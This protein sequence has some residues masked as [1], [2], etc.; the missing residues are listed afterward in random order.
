MPV[1]R[2]RDQLSFETYMPFY[3]MINRNN[4]WIKL[5]NIIPW[6]DIDLIYRR[7][8]NIDPD[9]GEYKEKELRRSAI[10]SRVAFGSIFIR[11][12]YGL[13]D[14]DTVQMISENIYS[15]HF[16]GLT[17]FHVEPLFDSSMMVYFRKRFPENIINAVN[18]YICSDG[19]MWPEEIKKII[20]EE[21]KRITSTDNGNSGDDNSDNNGGNNNDTKTDDKSSEDNTSNDDVKNKGTLIID[22]TVAPQKI[23][24]PTDISLLNDSREKVEKAIDI[25]WEKVPHEGHK[26]PYNQKSARQSF[27]NISKAKK[28]STKKMKKGIRKQLEYIDKGIERLYSFL[29]YNPDLINE[30]P[31]WLVERLNVICEVFNQQKYMLDNNTNKCPQRIVSL[32]QPFVRPIYRGKKPIATEFG[33][34]IHFSVVDGYTFVEKMSWENYNESTELEAAVEKYHE[35]YGFYP[36]AVLADRIYQKRANKKFCK[37]RGIRLSGPALG[38]K[39]EGQSEEEKKQMYIDSCNR[40]IVEGRIGL[41]KNRYGLKL[42]TSKL[43]ETSKTEVSMCVLVQNAMRKIRMDFLRLFSTLFYT[44]YSHSNHA[45]SA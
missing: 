33:L 35:K 21:K 17:E 30:L 14:R 26:Y 41:L 15:Q 45:C 42:I 44:R 8:M 13:S 27:L 7:T 23:T 40:N 6:D 22:A 24:Y 2:N 31:K 20:E 5:A 37:E 16:L 34:K 9:T 38:R 32:S 12:Y 4:P 25:I 29:E 1:D 43:D 19:S 18:E 39:R 3:D 10:T 36:E 28:V 11:C